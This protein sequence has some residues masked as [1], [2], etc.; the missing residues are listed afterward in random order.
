MKENKFTYLVP[1][2]KEELLLVKTSL[3]YLKLV[4]STVRIKNRVIDQKQLISLVMKVNSL[5]ERIH[6]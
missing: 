2:A 4:S 6:D 1:L 3:T 5:L